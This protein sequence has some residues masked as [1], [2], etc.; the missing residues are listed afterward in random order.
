ML[1]THR[2]LCRPATGLALAACLLGVPLATTSTAG[3]A[4]VP[5]AQRVVPLENRYCDSGSGY[6]CTYAGY[7]SDR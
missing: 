3:A 5:S 7:P 6:D 4:G 1:A 2:S